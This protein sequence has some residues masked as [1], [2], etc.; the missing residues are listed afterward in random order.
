MIIL[1]WANDHWEYLSCDQINGEVEIYLDEWVKKASATKR[2]N[3]AG[4]TQGVM[5]IGK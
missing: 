5:L 4:K 1:H 3:K 2:A